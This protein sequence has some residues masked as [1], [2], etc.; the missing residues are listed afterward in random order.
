MKPNKREI[1]K[2]ITLIQEGYEKVK[3]LGFFPGWFEEGFLDIDYC[4]R[5]A[6]SRLRK[7]MDTGPIYLPL[8]LLLEEEVDLWDEDE[9]DMWEKF[10][11]LNDMEFWG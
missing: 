1:K 9:Y 2:A 10:K 4:L 8:K 7:D 6:V 11:V 5:G 3:K